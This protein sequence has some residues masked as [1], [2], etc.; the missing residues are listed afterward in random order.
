M[1]TAILYSALAVLLLVGLVVLLRWREDPQASAGDDDQKSTQGFWDPEGLTLAER[2]FDPADYYW[3]RDYVG[4]PHLADSLYETRRRLA[5]AWLRAARRSFEDL[6]RIPE[7][8]QPLGGKPANHSGWQ[9]LGQVLRFQLVLAYAAFVVR[10]FGP[11]HSLV[12]GFRWIS[13]VP[14]LRLSED[15]IATSHSSHP[16]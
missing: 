10:Y 11:Y 7:P 12:P 15:T 4:F 16:R 14:D 5:L 2:I 13:P 8:P 9:L 3:L 1:T 6:L